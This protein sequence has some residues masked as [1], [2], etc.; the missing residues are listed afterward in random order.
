VKSKELFRRRLIFTVGKGG[1]GRTTV[2]IA[3]GLEAARQGLDVLLVELEGARGLGAALEAQRHAQSAPP[4]IE[5]LSYLAVD[6]KRALEEYLGLVIPVRRLLRTVFSSKIYQ[7]F[8]AAAPGLKEL[9]TIGKIWFEA[10]KS[11][12][13]RASRPHPDLVLIDAPATGHSLQ[14]LRMPQAALETFPTGLVHRE[15]ERIVSVLADPEATAVVVVTTAEEMPTNETTDI[16]RGLHAI[17]LPTTLLVVNQVHRVPCTQRELEAV[18]AALASL[19]GGSLGKAEREILSE[20]VARARDERGWAE[21]NAANIARL[22]AE[23]PIQTVTLPMLFA[24]EFSPEHVVQ[25]AA[26]LARQLDVRAAAP[27]PAPERS[28]RVRG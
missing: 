20:V 22:A 16:Y 23:V 21:I 27:R 8:V 2:T 26:E 1:V 28:R 9:M 10:Y 11:Q 17:G 14:Y 24:E 18:E 25:L 12:D 13:Q 5:R 6:G 15:A 4:G 7:Y 19:A 3:L